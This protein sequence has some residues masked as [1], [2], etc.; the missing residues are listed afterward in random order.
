MLIATVNH[1]TGV[2]N[3]FSGI[4][5]RR[6]VNIESISVGRSEV[7]GNARITIVIDV[8][9]LDEAEQVTKQLNRM[10]DV[11]KVQDITDEPHME[12]EVALVKLSAPPERRS[13]IF[14]MIEPF[15][16]NVIDVAS[17]SITVQITGTS[18]K[19]DAFVEVISPYGIKQIARTGATGLTRGN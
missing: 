19:I 10:I 9:D 14:S 17:R 13:E 5:T 7:K 2:L 16:T 4:L 8:D 1:T 12:R 15:R 18:D 6:Q 3:R 11:I